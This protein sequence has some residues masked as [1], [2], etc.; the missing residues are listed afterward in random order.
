MS[1]LNEH[2]HLQ[3]MLRICRSCGMCF[4]ISEEANPKVPASFTVS[5]SLR[6]AKTAEKLA[7]LRDLTKVV[8][9]PTI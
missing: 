3:Q 1:V 8:A 6:R 5:S 2:A 4:D 9:T 7:P